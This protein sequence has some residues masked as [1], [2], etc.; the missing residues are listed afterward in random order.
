MELMHW[1]SNITI[2]YLNSYFAFHGRIQPIT[3]ERGEQVTISNVTID[4]EVPLTT[5]SEVVDAGDDCP[6]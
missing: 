3:V 5:R 4:W 2:D 6:N 1:Q